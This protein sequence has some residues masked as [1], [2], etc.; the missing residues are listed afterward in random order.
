MSRV[1]LI[2]GAGSGIGAAVAE[3]A[4]ADGWQVTICGRRPGPLEQV[5]ART[6]A[7]PVVADVT[8]P[9]AV[10][11]L[12]D[13]TVADHGRLDCLVANA[14][15]MRGGS[16]ADLDPADW[17]LTLRT[18]LT[19]PYLLARA[20]LPHLLAS[21]RWG[22]GAGGDLGSGASGEWGS[23]PGGEPG[24]GPGAGTASRAAGGSIVAV[25]SIAALRA[26]SS[27]AGYAVSKAGLVMLTQSLAADFGPAGLRANVV[28]PGW[29]RTEMADQEMTE[30]G[31]PLGLDR[32]TAYREVTRLVPQRRPAEPAEIAAAITWLAGPDASY[33][34]G[35]CL[36]V[37]GGTVL[38]DPGTVG[39]DYSITPRPA[40]G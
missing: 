35:A 3:R 1:M 14:G 37:D 24:S 38:I 40:P 10:Q 28:C 36:V 4:A 2:T 27:A 21:G 12:V 5:A 6:G 33:V 18:N 20:A 23:G 25:S 22:S 31:A 30:F 32:D 8:D 26:S 39:L 13:G 15:V 29:V 7:R 16:V 17:E 11:A 34:N 9:A 19:A